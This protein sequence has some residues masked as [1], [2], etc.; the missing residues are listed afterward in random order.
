MCEL[1]EAE[2]S[3]VS[4]H[5]FRTQQ[6]GTSSGADAQAP[7]LSFPTLSEMATIYIIHFYVTPATCLPLILGQKA[8]S[9]RC[10]H[11]TQKVQ[12][13]VAVVVILKKIFIHG[14]QLGS[15]MEIEAYR[16]T[17]RSIGE[18]Q[19]YYTVHFLTNRH[20]DMI[21]VHQKRGKSTEEVEPGYN[22]ELLLHAICIISEQKEVDRRTY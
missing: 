6:A 10:Q 21:Q 4:S 18:A 17:I 7:F 1:T 22:S 15:P 9:S 14:I 13:I 19:R 2:P 3:S 5:M 20:D 11:C 12:E 16:Y 8:S